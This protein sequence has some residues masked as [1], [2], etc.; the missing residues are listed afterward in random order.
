MM[1]SRLIL[2]LGRKKVLSSLSDLKY[3]SAVAK[4]SFLPT[5]VVNWALG[6]FWMVLD[7]QLR[8]FLIHFQGIS[9]CPFQRKNGCLSL[10]NISSPPENRRV[11]RG[12]S[13]EDF[14]FIFAGWN[15]HTGCGEE[16]LGLIGWWMVKSGLEEPASEYIQSEYIQDILDHHILAT[17]TVLSIGSLCCV[18]KIKLG[19]HPAV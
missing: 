9:C 14:K 1:R 19:I 10:R 5:M 8:D 7:S 17:A 12:M 11:S 2:L 4:E 6:A 13:I 3:S 15:M 16:H 18:T